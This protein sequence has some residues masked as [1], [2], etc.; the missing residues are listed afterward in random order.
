[1]DVNIDEKNHYLLDFSRICIKN[2][3]LKIKCIS[4]MQSLL[5][6]S[7]TSLYPPKPTTVSKLSVLARQKWPTCICIN[8]KRS[9]KI[10]HNSF[11]LCMFV[12]IYTRLDFIHLKSP[13]KS[14][15]F[16]IL[17]TKKSSRVSISS[18]D[19]NVF[20]LQSRISWDRF[21]LSGL[22]RISQEFLRYPEAELSL[23]G[24]RDWQLLLWKC[25]ANWDKNLME[26]SLV[27]LQNCIWWPFVHSRWLPS[28]ET[29]KNSSPGPK[30]N[31]SYNV[32]GSVLV[33]RCP[34]IIHIVISWNL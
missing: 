7:L 28:A 19:K 21:L 22:P 6:L 4:Y 16:L 2:L 15:Q 12:W 17:K 25:K 3:S 20:P 24:K 11:A 1:M 5:L 8:L 29:F 30:E 23:S 14:W 18:E 26:W 13:D 34:S 27:P 9:C 31:V 10:T 32:I 33:I